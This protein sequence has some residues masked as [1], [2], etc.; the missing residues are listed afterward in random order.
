MILFCIFSAT[1]EPRAS[2]P[3][4]SSPVSEHDLVEGHS[5]VMSCE[6]SLRGCEKEGR[7]GGGEEEGGGMGTKSKRLI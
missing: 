7:R 1:G 4:L 3:L 6:L 5:D 2:S